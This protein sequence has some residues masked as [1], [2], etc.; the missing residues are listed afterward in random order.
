MSQMAVYTY[1]RIRK[2]LS[3]TA[4]LYTF[5]IFVVADSSSNNIHSD[6]GI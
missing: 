1:T 3:N 5:F 4:I 2:V 6:E